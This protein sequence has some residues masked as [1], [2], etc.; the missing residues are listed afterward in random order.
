LAVTAAVIALGRK[1]VAISEAKSAP[2]GVVDSA[3]S[4]EEGL[5]RFRAGIAPVDS[6]EGG[7][8]SREAL[9]RAFVKALETKDTTTL[10]RLSLAL[11]EFAYLYYETSPQS[12]PPYDLTPSLLWFMLERGSRGG[13]LKA[14]E[15]RGGA[16]LHYVRTRCDGEPSREGENVVYGPCVIVRRG[17]E[18]GDSLVER[19][20][21]QVIE[22]RG[23]WKFISYANKLD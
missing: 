5:R 13:L 21:G 10:R 19:L 14:L 12:L 16:P 22:R 18:R 9:V 1:H 2:T 3:I 15:G 11:R 20:F 23:R 17:G 8:S 7:E 6:L 4:R